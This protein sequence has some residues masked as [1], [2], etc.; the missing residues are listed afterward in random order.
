MSFG[1]NILYLYMLVYLVFTFKFIAL[2]L[3]TFLLGNIYN[4]SE[5]VDESK[6]Y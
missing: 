3:N 5:S 4:N 2:T 6:L 1:R